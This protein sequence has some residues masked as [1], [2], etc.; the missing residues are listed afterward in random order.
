MTDLVFKAIVAPSLKSSIEI[1]IFSYPKPENTM[2]CMLTLF[3]LNVKRPFSLV[4]VVL[5]IGNRVIVIPSIGS[6]VLSLITF[7]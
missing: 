7:P 4:V 3:S 6:L 2:D 1:I 5:F